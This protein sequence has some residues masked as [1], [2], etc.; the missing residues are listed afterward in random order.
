M[1][2]IKTALQVI[3]IL[4]ALWLAQGCVSLP[5]ACAK[6]ENCFWSQRVVLT[7]WGVVAI[8]E[9]PSVIVGYISWS[10]NAP[11]FNESPPI[12]PEVRP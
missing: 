2:Q 4:V 9:P 3:T 11:T 5:P 6:G 12:V 1:A 7:G 10:R 8:Y